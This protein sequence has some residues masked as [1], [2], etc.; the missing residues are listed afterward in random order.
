LEK[1]V[2][3]RNLFVQRAFKGITTLKTMDAEELLLHKC[4]NAVETKLG[5]EEGSSWTNHDFQALSTKIHEATG[6]NLSVATLKRIWGKVK[7]DSKPTITTLNTL[8]QFTGYENWRDF[9]QKHNGLEHQGIIPEK[10]AQVTQNTLPGAGLSGWRKNVWRFAIIGAAVC[11]GILFILLNAGTRSRGMEIIPA[12]YSFSSKK[13]VSKGVPNSV[14][15]DYDA[16]ASPTDTIY[17]Q[18]SWDERLRTL[19]S[20]DQHQHTSIYYTPGFF[21]AKLVIGNTIVKEHNLLI[22]SNGW[23]ALVKQNPVPVYFKDEDFRRSGMLSLP[24]N[25][26]RE[27]NIPFQPET[28][29]T[30]YYNVRDFGDLN[31][32]NFVF[33]TDVRSDYKEGSGICQ[34]V[35]ILLLT[36]GDV[37][38]IPLSIKGCVSD[39]SLLFGTSADGKKVDLSSFGCDLSQWVKLRCEVKDKKGKITING[40]VAFENEF[41]AADKI[42]GLIYR[43][44]GT[45]SVNEVKLSAD[46]KVV[47]EDGF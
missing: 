16:A 47:Y 11:G 42:V 25:K 3:K 18:Q 6:V 22:N 21:Q 28:P 10:P 35:Q 13:I 31:T 8:A 43:F 32:G 38:I 30:S 26:L 7:Y 44:Q 36:E 4:R 9:K 5:W 1:P 14:V 37:I 33:E 12:Q 27:N 29:W 24:L 23:L 40:Q 46:D 45:G 39:L 17:I 41:T 2:Q 20:R 34:R 19:V 15:F